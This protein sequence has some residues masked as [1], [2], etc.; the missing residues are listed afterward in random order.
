M[1]VL[2]GRSGS[3]VTVEVGREWFCGEFRLMLQWCLCPSGGVGFLPR[4]VA[5]RG[6]M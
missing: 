1:V 3:G 2:S 4:L 5:E 6:S